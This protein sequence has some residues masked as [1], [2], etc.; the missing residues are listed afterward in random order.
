MGGGAAGDDA[1]RDGREEAA[2]ARR[3]RTPSPQRRHLTRVGAA[4][5]TGRVSDAMSGDA[6]Q[7][8]GGAHEERSDDLS[9]DQCA[10]AAASHCGAGIWDTIKGSW[11]VSDKSHQ[12]GRA[13]C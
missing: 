3:E 12:R 7:R 6:C 9:G 10:A 5:T 11:R 13:A 2:T 4:R 8:L 1:T